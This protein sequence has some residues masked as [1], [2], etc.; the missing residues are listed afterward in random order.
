MRPPGIYANV[1]QADHIEVGVRARVVLEA[2]HDEQ[3]LV[4]AVKQQLAGDIGALRLGG[5]VLFSQTLRA[6]VEQPG[7]VDVQGLHLRRCP[8]TF[9]RVSF[10]GVPF[11][12]G[13][14]EASVG[15]N[16]LMGRTE[17]ALFQLDGE[18]I[19]IEVVTR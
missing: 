17:I 12:Q 19:Q 4:A 18:L 13:V 8:A 10:G 15:E 5:A 9:G 7:V 3:A 16:L 11:Q 2:G 6:F 14:V 1:I